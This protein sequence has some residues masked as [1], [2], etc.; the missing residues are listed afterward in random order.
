MSVFSPDECQLLLNLLN[1]K[2]TFQGEAV[3]RSWIP[4]FD[5]LHEGIDGQGITLSNSISTQTTQ[6]QS[7]IEGSVV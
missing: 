3:I 5:K 6:S 1:D 7:S 4:I 2:I